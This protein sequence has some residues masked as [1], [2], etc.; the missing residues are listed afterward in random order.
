LQCEVAKCAVLV[1]TI[2]STN[3]SALLVAMME[4]ICVYK[5]AVLAYF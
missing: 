4:D 1:F 3:L 5:G 2:K